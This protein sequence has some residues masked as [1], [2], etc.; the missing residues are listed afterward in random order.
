MKKVL[1][2]VIGLCLLGFLGTNK[3]GAEWVNTQAPDKPIK[4]IDTDNIYKFNNGVV[5]A[6]RYMN[7]KNVDMLAKFYADF[8][9]DKFG[10]FSIR[11]YR[12]GLKYQYNVSDN[13]EMRDINMFKTDFTE[14]RKMAAAETVLQCPTDICPGAKVVAENKAETETETENEAE[15]SNVN[16]TLYMRELEKS[17]KNNWNPPKKLTTKQ[18]IIFFTINKNGS[19]GESRIQKSSGDALCDETA[20]QAVRITAPFKPLLEEFDGKS[21]DIEFTFDYRVLGGNN[22]SKK[23]GVK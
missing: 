23:R 11:P 1:I 17:I 19:L 21:I 13:L 16:W 6:I 20:L 15:A 18:V 9:N 2:S 4:L 3:A 14:I 12:D 8:E 5:F 7:Q 22:K 10:V